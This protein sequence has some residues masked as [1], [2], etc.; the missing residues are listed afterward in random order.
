MYV[1]WRRCGGKRKVGIGS[2]QSPV[3][4]MKMNIRNLYG[5]QVGM[6]IGWMRMRKEKKENKRENI[7]SYME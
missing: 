6:E 4:K 3:K 1:R 2:R 5:M 7:W